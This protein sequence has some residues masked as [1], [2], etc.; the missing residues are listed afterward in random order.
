MTRK[1]FTNHLLQLGAT[2]REGEPETYFFPAFPTSII[3]ITAVGA[4]TDLGMITL[5][6]EDTEK[7]EEDAEND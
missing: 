6:E 5:F 3:T 4:F 7:F 1:K 2:R